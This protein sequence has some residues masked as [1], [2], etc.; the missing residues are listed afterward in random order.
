MSLRIK[1]TVEGVSLDLPSVA[2]PSGVDPPGELRTPFNWAFNSYAIQLMPRSLWVNGTCYGSV[3]PG[4]HVRFEAAGIGEVFVNGH[5]REP[6]PGYPFGSQAG[7]AR[8]GVGK[9]PPS[10][11]PEGQGKFREGR[12]VAMTKT[13]GEGSEERAAHPIRQLARRRVARFGWVRDLPDH[14]DQLFSV[15][16][17]VLAELPRSVD[18]RPKCPPV[19]DQ[20]RIG[21]CTANAI[22]G[23]IHFDRLKSG[24][25]PDFVPS[26][27]FIYYNERYIEHDVADDAGAQLRD[28]IKSVHKLG[29]CPEPEWPYDDT[30]A[31]SDGGP[32]PPGAK[33][34]TQPPPSCYADAAKYKAVGYQRLVQNLSQF[35]GCLAQGFPFVFG[36]VV[37]DSFFD[38]AT[39]KQ[40]VVTPLPADSDSPVGGHAVLC[41]GYDNSK[42]LFTCRNSW[43]ASEGDGGYFYMPFS[44]LTDPQLASDF[45]V[46]RT[47]AH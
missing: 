43:G 44:Y 17:T 15:P 28:G 22:A 42:L 35:R 19:Y 3:Q 34:A 36:F 31:E 30:P 23:A 26:R 21:S 1:L 6:E 39:N 40:R 16:H 2:P 32:W 46:I 37:Y 27:L 9:S 13:Y 11:S 5:R 47:I 8:G 18:L 41:V 38:P 25:S 29:V 10:T 7:E 24:Q 33:P 12:E 14:R 20:G 45:W 4:E